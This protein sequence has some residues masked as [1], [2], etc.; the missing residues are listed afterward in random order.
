L[1]APT[2]E[3]M[4]MPVVVNMVGKLLAPT[5]VSSNKK[6]KIYFC[7]QYKK[8]KLPLNIIL[9]REDYGPFAGRFAP[10]IQ[11]IM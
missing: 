8:Y 11:A 3:K 6:K 4:A 9:S 5:P 10:L 1:W 2:N 7:R